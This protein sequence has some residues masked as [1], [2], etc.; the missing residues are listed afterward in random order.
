MQILDLSP[1]VPVQS[2]DDVIAERERQIVAFQ[3]TPEQDA[4]LPLAFL[5]KEARA[6]LDG[7]IDEILIGREGWQQ[8]ARRK[9]AKVGALTLAALDRLAAEGGE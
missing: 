6:Y 2:I 9:L 1:A 5:P 8:R 3:H 7:A 4:L